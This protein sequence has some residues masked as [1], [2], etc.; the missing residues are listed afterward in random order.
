MNESASVSD[1]DGQQTLLEYLDAPS[2]QHFIDGIVTNDKGKTLLSFTFPVPQFDP[3]ACLEML[4]DTANEFNFYWEKPDQQLAFSAG[5]EVAILKNKGDGRFESIAR[6]V[7]EIKKQS[8]SFSLLRHSLSGIHLLGGFSFFETVKSRWWQSFGSGSL[9]VPEWLLIQDGKLGLLTITLRYSPGDSLETITGKLELHL[10]R[11]EQLFR[12]NVELPDFPLNGFKFNRHSISSE[13]PESAWTNNV[14]QAKE[15]IAKKKFDKIVLARE[16]VRHTD[17]PIVVTQVMNTLRS[18]YPSCYNFLIRDKQGKAFLGC[19]PERLV[20]FKKNYLLT[21][22]LAGSVS[23]GKTATEDVHLEKY[24]LNSEKNRREHQFVTSAIEEHL[25][26]FTHDIERAE[27]PDVK[28]LKNV[29]HLYT[30]V[31]AW[32]KED[33]NQFSILNKLHPTPAVGGHPRSQAVPYIDSL[34]EFDRGWY[35]GP[36]GWFNLNGGGEFA[37]AIRSSLVDGN[38][39]RVFAGCGIVED[40]DPQTEWEETNLKLMP[41]LSALENNEGKKA[42]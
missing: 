16:V 37:V 10:Q 36:V 4:P 14:E 31:R 15:L 26:P 2:L 6:Q 30:P 24:L 32:L 38:T 21:D 42:G 17:H 20:S 5:G 34:E 9:T 23:R 41:I 8:A 22:S 39:A 19:S 1:I 7:D 18:Q 28:K 3:L 40:S 12:L 29:Q 13:Q 25:Q 33:T 11:F 27:Q 35:A